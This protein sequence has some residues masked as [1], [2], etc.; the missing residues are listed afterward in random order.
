MQVPGL[1][2][3]RGEA[4]ATVPANAC[5]QG[6]SDP[7]E[8]RCGPSTD[9]RGLGNCVTNVNRAN[10][11]ARLETIQPSLHRQLVAISST[12]LDFAISEAISS[13]SYGFSL[14]LA[15]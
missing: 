11:F 13:L 1:S 2:S 7:R 14:S 15:G 10:G 12:D 5:A 3:P 8:T 4:D 9:A 6:P